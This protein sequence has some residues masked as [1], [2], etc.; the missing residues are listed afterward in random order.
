[1]HSI[2]I[3]KLFMYFGTTSV[4]NIP[5]CQMKMDIITVLSV[6]SITLFVLLGIFLLFSR[7]GNRAAN[8]IL[9]C[10]FVLWALDFLDGIL[11][12]SGFFLQYPSAA[13][14]TE[15]LVLLYGPLIYM[16]TLY[17]TDNTTRL[18][19]I[20][21]FHLIPFVLFVVLT[22]F[23][24]HFQ[25]LEFKM[26][27]LNNVVNLEFNAVSYLVF[28]LFYVHIFTYIIY[29]KKRIKK[30]RINI[31]SY[32]SNHHIN[33]LQKLLDALMVILLISLVSSTLQLGGPRFYFELSL[34]LVLLLVVIFIG[35]LI[36][37]A[38]DE[39]TLLLQG[40]LAS[41]S[42]REQLDSHT[43]TEIEKKVTQVLAEEK[44]YLDPE[45]TLDDLASAVGMGP[46][47]VS[48]VINEKMG[49]HFFDLINTYRIKEAQRVLEENKD[50]KKTILE[51][52]YEV[53]FNSKSSFNTQFKKI[54]G[55][56]PTEFARQARA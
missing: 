33:R 27:V 38:M 16:Y 1:M 17:A 36:V 54:T 34:T 5:Y 8:T 51:I 15:P 10:F 23:F 52:M 4:Q 9:G 29:S 44:L 42:G 19:T 12:L 37:R 55:R 26:S 48:Q 56:T 45:L 35:L 21:L 32:Y 22:L 30:V 3:K 25:P 28:L 18:G 50:P 20:H 13:L 6:I 43:S 31:E 47:L 46:R 39:P 24:Y 49:K 53:G 14:W 11:M 2:Y 41:G 7:K 40:E